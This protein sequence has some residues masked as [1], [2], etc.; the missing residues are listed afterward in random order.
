MQQ[1]IIPIYTL[2]QIIKERELKLR[3]SDILVFDLDEKELSQIE[4]NN[5]WRI[6]SLGIIL[7][8]GGTATANIDSKKVELKEM[9]IIS[10][11][12]NTI[13]E[14]KHFSEDC[15]IKS[16]LISSGFRSELDCQINSKEAF[17]ILSNNYSKCISLDKS[18]FSELV[19]HIDKIRDLNNPDHNNAFYLNMIKLHLSLITYEMSNYRTIRASTT[20]PLSSRKEDIAVEF[21]NLVENNFRNYKDVQYYADSMHI[22]RKHLTRTIKEVLDITPK[23][24][25]ENKIITEAKVLLL[26]NKLDINQIITELNFNDQPTFSK[27]FKKNTGLTP[28]L[29][30]K[31]NQ[32]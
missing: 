17:D 5:P 25:I 3:S 31:Q 6:A 29:Y 4:I 23:Q 16:M 28:G 7:I 22:T 27:L 8:T 15:K 24:V 26:N 2:Q 19:Y 10:L 1:T 12:P 20:K 32:K 11:F 14:F 21:I 18:V 30:R 13:I 9:D